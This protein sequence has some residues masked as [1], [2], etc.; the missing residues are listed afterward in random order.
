MAEIICAATVAVAVAVALLVTRVSSNGAR[1]R[2]W[3]PNNSSWKGVWSQVANEASRWRHSWSHFWPVWLVLAP[4]L[5]PLRMTLVPHC[6]VPSK[7][8]AE[9]H[10]VQNARGAWDSMGSNV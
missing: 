1:R 3:R 5:E 10:R 7:E 6:A 2:M 4:H 8:A 9:P